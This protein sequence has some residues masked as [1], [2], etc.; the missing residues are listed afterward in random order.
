MKVLRFHAALLPTEYGCVA[1]LLDDP[2]YTA[3]APDQE[4][5]ERALVQ[6]LQKALKEDPWMSPGECDEFQVLIVPVDLRPEYRVGNQLLPQEYSWEFRLPCAVGEISGGLRMCVVPS[7]G[8]QFYFEGERSLRELV[9]HYVQEKLKGLNPAQL[10]RFVPGEGLE[11]RRLRVKKP[12]TSRSRLEKRW[13]N[14]EGVAE[15]AH[16]ARDKGYGREDSLKQLLK[17]L[18][19]GLSVAVIG[20]ASVGKTT[21]IHEAARRTKNIWRT[22]A[23]RLIA[24]MSYLGMWEERCERVVSELGQAN[25][26]LMVESLAELIRQGGQDPGGSLAAFLAPYLVDGQLQMVVE[27][28][29]SEWQACRRLLPG[30]ADLFRVLP[31][32]PMNDAETV[33]VLTWVRKGLRIGLDLDETLLSLFRRFSP[34]EA[35]PGGAVRFLRHIGRG[36]KAAELTRPRLIEA[37]SK[38]SSIPEEFLLDE[39]GIEPDELLGQLAERV[40][41]QPEAHQA[42]LRIITAFKAGLQDPGRPLGVLLLCGPTGV[43]KTELAKTLAQILFADE[44]R[45]IRL[46]MSEYAGAGAADRLLG[47]LYDKTPA[48]WLRELRQK[49]FSVVLFDEVEKAHPEVF[50]VLMRAFDEGQLCDPWGRI[51]SLRTAVLILTSNLGAEQ[52]NALGLRQLEGGGYSQAVLRYFRPELVNRLD[53]VVPFH[54]LSNEVVRAV[55]RREI[56][57]LARR[58]GLKRRNLEIR[59]SERCLDQLA[60]LG[61]DARLGARPLQRLIERRLIPQLTHLLS[62]PDCPSRLLVDLDGD[63]FFLRTEPE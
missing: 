4:G 26:I 28:S 43:G 39:I 60:R 35:L 25:G 49:P 62:Q 9:G 10:L 36:P 17:N 38:Q 34:Y 41:G 18:Q 31:L 29:A 22:S 44:K 53:A 59:A 15:L 57:L 58:P 51:T 30:F 45:L 33:E 48:P 8:L 3:H 14:L 63:E 11:I 42:A 46:D 61:Y 50:D 19:A 24:G 20:P 12:A 21:L 32:E 52:Q 16:T 23:A 1:V 55:A 27:A 13:E 40:I 5:A 47:S 7:L 2:A 37:F 54:P 6:L 56:A